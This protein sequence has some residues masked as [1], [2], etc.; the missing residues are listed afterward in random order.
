MRP[1]HA[2]CTKGRRNQRLRTG[3]SLTFLIWCLGSN[4]IAKDVVLPADRFPGFFFADFD[5]KLFPIPTNFE[6]M[7]YAGPGYTF[8][9]SSP[10]ASDK[11]VT[12]LM[13]SGRSI[14]PEQLLIAPIEVCEKTLHATWKLI[15]TRQRFGLK[16]DSYTYKPA[17]KLDERFTHRYA[18]LS[19]RSCVMSAGMSRDSFDNL[20]TL[21]GKLN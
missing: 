3:I 21:Y 17:N 13:R 9:F 15:D 18:A 5:G 12:A 16:I 2:T 19:G 7:R 10:A 20:I 4:C 8:R 1:T 11:D 14:K 6:A